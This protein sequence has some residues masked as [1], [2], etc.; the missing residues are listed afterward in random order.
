MPT[1]GLS[2]PGA[3]PGYVVNLEYWCNHMN[4]RL[5]L[6]VKPIR[7]QAFKLS[8]SKDVYLRQRIWLIYFQ[9]ITL[10]TLIKK[11][12]DNLNIE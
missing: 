5:S 11:Q 8:T 10:K 6:E 1:Q 2:I 9:A 7:I 4:G 3:E 12:D